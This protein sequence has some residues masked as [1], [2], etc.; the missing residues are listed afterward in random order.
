[1]GSVSLDLASGKKVRWPNKCA[2]C[3][4]PATRW[5]EASLTSATSLRYYV[6]ALGWKE[7]T[8][9]ISYPVCKK[10]RVLCNLLN[11]PSKW[12]FINSFLFL[13]FVPT[14]FWI[15]IGLLLAVS[16]GIKGSDL[17]PISTIVAILTYGSTILFFVYCAL[18]KPI[19]I[20]GVSGTLI[21]LKMTNNNFFKE[22]I[23]HNKSLFE[24]KLE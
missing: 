13:V 12:G 24:M 11:L 5:A 21:R 16:L 6:V 4:A 9:S 10:H 18:R 14:F 7:Q 1:M 15:G 19:R 2:F 8:H 23:N 22:F 17:S 3:D 20:S